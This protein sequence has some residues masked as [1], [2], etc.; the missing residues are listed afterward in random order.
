MAKSLE[1]LRGIS[2][3]LRSKLSFIKSPISGNLTSNSRHFHKHIKSEDARG[4]HEKAF[5]VI[6]EDVM[7][8]YL[9]P[10]RGG[11]KFVLAVD[12]DFDHETKPE[13]RRR[14]NYKGNVRVLGSV[15]WDDV[16][17]LLTTQSTTL[18]DI[19]PLAMNRPHGIYAGSRVTPVLK[20]SSYEELLGF[21]IRCAILPGLVPSVKLGLWLT[22]RYRRRR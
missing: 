5:L 20:F 4:A 8:S 13:D 19:W 2:R 16:G 18:D 22:A 12:P 17:A 3:L 15:L 14:P 6:D 10:V 11:E 1:S 9:D 7:K 21:Q